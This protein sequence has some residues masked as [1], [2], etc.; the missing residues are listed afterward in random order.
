MS[1]KSLQNKYSYWRDDSGP[2]LGVY[3]YACTAGEI[4]ELGVY[5]KS[6]PTRGTVNSAPDAHKKAQ[7]G[8]EKG[9]DETTISVRRARSSLSRCVGQHQKRDA[10]GKKNATAGRKNKT[11]PG[12]GLQCS[13]PRTDHLT[14]Q[15]LTICI[16]LC[17][18]R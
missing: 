15:H 1:A 5:Q 11:V 12:C 3:K 4:V 13:T 7:L 17:Q 16:D 14:D 6:A 8:G 2:V 10:A 18:G 9:A